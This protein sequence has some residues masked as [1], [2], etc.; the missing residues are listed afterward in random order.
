MYNFFDKEIAVIEKDIYEYPTK[1][2]IFSPS[3]MYPEYPFEESTIAQQDNMV[4]EMVRDGFIMLG[5]DKEK[6]GTCDWNPL[7][8]FISP[9]DYV[10]LKP[11][12]VLDEN[13][14]KENGTDCLITNPA[15]IRAVLDFVV[16]ALGNTGHIVLGDAPL[17]SCNFDKLVHEQ[18]FDQ[19]V[20]FY[21]KR[22]IH[23]ELKDFRLVKSCKKYGLVDI[24]EKKEARDC[25]IVD[26]GSISEQ[27]N[28][29]YEKLRVTSYNSDEMKKHHNFKKHEYLIASPVLL[30]DVIINL[31]KPKTH[32]KAGLTGALKNL[33]GING[34]K[35][36][37]PHHRKGSVSEGGDEYL[38][39][40]IFKKAEADVQ[41]LMNKRIQKKKKFFFSQVL[42]VLRR[43]FSIMS[44]FTETDSYREG[45]WFGNDT[46]WRTITDLNRI[47][48]YCDKEGGLTK[49]KQRKIFIIGDMIVSGEGEGPLM[50]TPIKK[51][52]LIFGSN[53]VAFDTIVA[54]LM[55][56]DYLKIPS[57]FCN[58]ANST[59][60]LVDFKKDEIIVKSN[61]ENILDGVKENFI[62][63]AGWGGHIELRKV[64]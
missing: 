26:I 32:R 17:Q 12:M 15:I 62:P 14:I 61:H 33:I 63:S 2:Y 20:D 9:G 25:T 5:L 46:I 3:K 35:D 27:K 21:Y 55:G 28:E 58:Y 48:L 31:P 37:L 34:N 40:N 8:E 41:D 11:N 22:G 16:I 18:G 56:F 53:P 49:T 47:L 23:I 42:R 4:Y 7:G 13:E 1:E 51:G 50:P 24:I 38:N 30:A 29:N 59:Y 10:L 39:S 6:I 52:I 19:L 60:P 43:G 44:K 45:S 57:I 64:Q 36:W 54:E